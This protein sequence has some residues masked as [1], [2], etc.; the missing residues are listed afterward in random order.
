MALAAA[1]QA[2]ILAIF[3]WTWL[4]VLELGGPSLLTAHVFI[5]MLWLS[6]C[7][8]LLV[9]FFPTNRAPPAGY[10][11]AVLAFSLSTFF[12]I[13]DTFEPTLLVDRRFTPPG[14]PTNTTPLGTTT[15]F[16]TANC[17]LARMHQVF[18]FSGSSMYLIYAGS[19]IGY[20]V[21]QLL[22]AAS[23][24]LDVE[25]R[26]S[27]WPGPAWGMALLSLLAFRGFVTFDGSASGGVEV[28]KQFFYFK[29]FS[30]PILLLSVAFGAAFCAGM[31]LLV[32]EG[33]F[34][35]SLIQRKFVRLF[36]LGFTL[37]FFVASSLVFYDKGMLTTSLFIVLSLTIL[38]AIVGAVQANKAREISFSVHTPTQIRLP[39]SGKA[40]PRSVYNR[41]APSSGRLIRHLIPIP[42]EMQSL[43][44]KNKVV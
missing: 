40:N 10:F 4:T 28:D 17:T 11:G 23:H 33:L 42:V 1:V 39:P 21:V 8:L 20:L 29:L 12:C 3:G 18:Y 9:A 27:I 26:S 31:F 7:N 2:W 5:G 32:L 14:G 22:V 19:V 37:L 44:E 30:E 13:L 35:Q 34:M 25:R 6:T 43:S 41:V 38:P 24:M 15:Q 16:Q 36:A